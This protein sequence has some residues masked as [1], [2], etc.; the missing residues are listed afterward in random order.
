[1]SD[2]RVL[3]SASKTITGV[4]LS[5]ILRENPNFG[6]PNV[7]KTDKCMGVPRL[8][9]RAPRLPPKSKPMKQGIF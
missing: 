4:D 1:M 2:L 7:L 6:E 3:H 8:L 9:V 5:K